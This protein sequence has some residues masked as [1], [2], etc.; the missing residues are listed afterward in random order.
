MDGTL[1]THDA[2]VRSEIKERWPHREGRRRGPRNG[3]DVDP[4]PLGVRALATLAWEFLAAE[5]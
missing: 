2:T 3:F 4:L 1:R 5:N